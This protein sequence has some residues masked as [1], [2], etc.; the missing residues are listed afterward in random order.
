MSV[1]GDGDSAV[2][3]PEEEETVAD[4]FAARKS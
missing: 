1:A 2:L 4:E 3:P